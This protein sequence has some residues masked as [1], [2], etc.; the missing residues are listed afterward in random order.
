MV[1]FLSLFKRLWGIAYPRGPL[2]ELVGKGKY[3]EL[4]A[5][6]TRQL[7]MSG[8][9]LPSNFNNDDVVSVYW[10]T[11][12]NLRTLNYKSLNAVL[13][14][15]HRPAKR[16]LLELCAH[17]TVALEKLP[18]YTGP[19]WRTAK[20]DVTVAAPHVT[21]QSVQY[22]A[23]TSTSRKLRA[24]PPPGGSYIE[25]EVR[26]GRYIGGLSRFAD[27]EEVLL[28]PGTTFEVLTNRVTGGTREIHMVE[29]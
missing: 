22:P 21:G 24:M 11:H 1:N 15:Q 7:V 12:Q 20:F 16:E 2:C 5:L 25:V 3:R 10:Y 29:I 9:R 23:F 6:G 19:C 26:T 17:L 14:G 13:W 4:L 8:M 27:E 28:L 18:P